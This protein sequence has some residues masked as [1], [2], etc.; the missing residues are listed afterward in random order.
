MIGSMAQMMDKVWIEEPAARDVSDSIEAIQTHSN[1][2]FPIG[3]SNRVRH[4]AF[5]LSIQQDLHR[6]HQ[7]DQSKGKGERGEEAEGGQEEGEA[8]REG[9]GSVREGEGCEEQ[10]TDQL[11]GR[12]TADH[13]IAVRERREEEGQREWRRPQCGRCHLLGSCKLIK[14]C[15]EE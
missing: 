4:Q 13:L 7:E 1:L 9:Q 14:C 2:H 10:Q 11:E 15:S 12:L 3:A 6:A 5:L 8:G